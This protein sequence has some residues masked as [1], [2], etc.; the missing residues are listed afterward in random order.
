MLKYSYLWFVNEEDLFYEK[1]IALSCDDR[2]GYLLDHSLLECSRSSN[3]GFVS[4]SYNMAQ[5]YAGDGRVYVKRV[6]IE[7]VA[8]INGDEGQFAKVPEKELKRDKPSKST[9]K[10]DRDER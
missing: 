4:T 9:R 1:S 6:S 5:D 2:I 7:D 3:G 8:W 10:S